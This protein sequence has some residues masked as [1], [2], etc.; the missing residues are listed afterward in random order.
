MLADPYQLMR[1][2]PWR[3]LLPYVVVVGGPEE[4]DG[5]TKFTQRNAVEL[6]H[7]STPEYL[8]NLTLFDSD[9]TGAAIRTDSETTCA[10][11]GAESARPSS[12]S[13]RRGTSRAMA[14]AESGF[15]G[16]LGGVTRGL[17]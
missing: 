11:P 17:V 7:S 13:T 3:K 8:L 14:L 2:P 10:L 15:G 12:R 9:E 1:R 4:E 16:G 5:P 6:D